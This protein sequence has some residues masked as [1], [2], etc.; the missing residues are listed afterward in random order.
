MALISMN[1]P[2]WMNQYFKAVEAQKAMVGSD[3]D[4]IDTRDIKA[5][6]YMTL[7]S[8]PD[9]TKQRCY[10][11]TKVHL[12]NWRDTPPEGMELNEASLITAMAELKPPR[13][14]GISA[15]NFPKLKPIKPREAMTEY[16]SNWGVSQQKWIDM[17]ERRLTATEAV[18]RTK[19]HERPAYPGTI[20]HMQEIIQGL[21]IERDK[22]RDTALANERD[23]KKLALQ[24]A[25]IC[26][27]RDKHKEDSELRGIAIEGL[28]QAN[29]ELD[30]AEDRA[31]SKAEEWRARALKAEAELGKPAKPNTRDMSRVA[32]MGKAQAM[33][34]LPK[35]DRY[36]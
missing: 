27:E 26:K 18:E 25:E 13:S 16:D 7:A 17:L 14:G 20:G 35:F 23:T 4:L 29:K 31:L 33:Q 36:Y 32:N 19:A 5:K 8:L 28:L 12:G 1:D 30:G 11:A 10:E 24:C 3:T 21:S 2:D 15:S 9:E 34:G 6:A 22:W